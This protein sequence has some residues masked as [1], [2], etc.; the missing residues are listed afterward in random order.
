MSGMSP[1]LRRFGKSVGHEGPL[2][3][4]SAEG[5]IEFGGLDLVGVEADLLDETSQESYFNHLVHVTTCFIC[6]DKIRG[7]SV[8]S[9]WSGFQAEAG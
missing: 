5:F 9:T 1:E 7:T 8:Q 6:I 4:N 2:L 3:I